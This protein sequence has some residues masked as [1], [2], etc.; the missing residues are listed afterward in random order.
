VTIPAGNTAVCLW[1]GL[2]FQQINLTP[3]GTETLTNKTLTNPTV[4]NYTESLVAIGNSGT[5]KTIS[6]TSGTVQTVTMTGNCTFTMPT[7][8]ASKSFVLIVNTGAGSFTAT[9]TGVK[10][11]NNVTPV[12][13]T[14][15]ARYDIF[16]FIADGTSWFGSYSQ[17]YQ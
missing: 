10:F 9:F 6:L 1:T 5:A 17:A 8:T 15:A 11:P 2:D 7:A 4:T 3:T 14:T 13:T 12:L 16:T